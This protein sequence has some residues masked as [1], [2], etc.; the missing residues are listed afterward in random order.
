MSFWNIL[1]CGIE[2]TMSH[3]APVVNKILS[4]VTFM[5]GALRLP[6]L[7]GTLGNPGCGLPAPLDGAQWLPRL[8]PG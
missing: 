1:P 3:G 4:D 8:R 2:G 7:L 5:L 6:N